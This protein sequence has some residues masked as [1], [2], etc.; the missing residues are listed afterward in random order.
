MT[1]IYSSEEEYICS[2]LNLDKTWKNKFMVAKK[3]ICQSRFDNSL[4]ICSSV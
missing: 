3:L 1:Q 4:V 2:F